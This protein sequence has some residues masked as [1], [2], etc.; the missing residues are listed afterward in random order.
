[1]PQLWS[2]SPTNLITFYFLFFLNST[3]VFSFE[4]HITYGK[5][6]NPEYG[7]KFP[8]GVMQLEKRKCIFINNVSEFR[9]LK[10]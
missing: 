2:R 5:D 7:F 3:S 10:G 8:E 9:T 4:D 6:L 1:M